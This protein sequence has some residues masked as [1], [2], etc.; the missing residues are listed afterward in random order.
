LEEGRGDGGAPSTLILEEELQAA[1]WL[2]D[3]IKIPGFSA[4][5]F[6]LLDVSALELRKGS[7]F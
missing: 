6:Q 1:A 5:V 3:D 7:F 2:V 4:R